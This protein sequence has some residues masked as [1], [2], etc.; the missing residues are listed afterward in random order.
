METFVVKSQTLNVM[1]EYKDD[2]LVVNGSFNKDV[3][4]DALLSISGQCYRNNGGIQGDY[5]GNFNGSPS[6]DEIRYD[7]S[8]MSRQDSNLVW[9][10]IGNIEAEILP[11]EA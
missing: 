1:Y 6:G 4:N 5:V 3:S 2:S 7:L 10:A 9:N 11:Q 8:Q